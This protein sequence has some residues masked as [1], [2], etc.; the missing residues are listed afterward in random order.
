MGTRLENK[1]IR[2]SNKN[3]RSKQ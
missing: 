2:R 1:I 3:P